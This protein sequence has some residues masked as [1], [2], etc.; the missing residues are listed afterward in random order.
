MHRAESRT[1]TFM[2]TRI[3]LATPA[4]APAIVAIYRPHVDD[5]VVSFELVAPDAAEMRR[6]MDAVRCGGFPWLCVVGADDQALGYAYASKLRERA[7]YQWA[8][9][10][11]IYVRL[12][13]AR[14]GLGRKLYGALA[15]I[16]G[17]QGIRTAIGGIT[18]PNPGSVG[19]HEAMGFRR[20]GIYQAVGYKFGAWHDVGFWQLELAPPAADPPPP[21]RFD[22]LADPLAALEPVLEHTLKHALKHTLKHE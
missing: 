21:R 16:L 13:Q 18:L 4:D 6:R 3:R 5:T 7:A 17:L 22:E 2:D 9:E 8:V 19:L 12:D 15:G 20:A 10:T 14:R 11:T 1:N